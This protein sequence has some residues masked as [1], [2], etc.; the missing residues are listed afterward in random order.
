MSRLFLSLAAST[1]LTCSAL[2]WQP[3]DANAETVFRIANGGEPSTI[4]PHGVSGDWENRIVGD[5]FMGL[6]T[7]DVQA[8]PIPGAAESWEISDD[9]LVYTFKIRDHNWSDGT[10]VTAGDFE[11]ALQRILDPETAA[12][13]ASLLYPIKNAAALNDGSMEG[14]ENLGVRSIDDS[15]LEITLE[16]PTSY[17]L[18][19]LTHYTA[20]PVPKHVIEEH[21]KD[22]VKP[23]NHVSNGPYKITE[24]VPND[25]ITAVKNEEFYDA[26]SLAIDKVVFYQD[27]DRNSMLRRFR[28]DEIDYATELPT[29]QIDWMRENIPD[30]VRISPMLGIYY[31]PVNT[32]LEP[33]S[34]ERVRQAL[35]MAI[36]RSAIT[37]KVLKTGEVPA[38]S[39]VP[40]GAGGSY[41]PAYAEWKDLSYEERL[42]QAKTLMAEAGYGP[43]NPLQMQLKYNTSENHKRVAIAAAAMWKALGVQV[44]LLNQELKVH[45]DQL[46]E[47]DFEIARAGWLADY[48]DP[49]NFLYLLETATGPMNYGRYDNSEFDELMAQAATSTEPVERMALMQQAEQHAMNDMPVIPLYYYVSRNLVGEN[50][51]GWEDNAKDIHRTRWISFAE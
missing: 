12:E 25:H 19:L 38:Y 11:F 18:E 16:N 33:Y 30:A 36:D 39:F 48:N 45:Y 21:G 26:D 7:E 46:Q 5:M 15:T 17:F 20:F 29:E 24:W 14:M 31:Y 51:E 49:Q 23:G 44:E 22:W 3:S 43:D 27:E 35:A 8:S 13:Y 2:A 4:D 1:I 50:V 47:N 9:G 32:T 37:D 41:E 40:P 28:A 42:E 10:P 34:D 6:L